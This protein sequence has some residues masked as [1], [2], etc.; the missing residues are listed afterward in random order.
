MKKAAKANSANQAEWNENVD[1][2][3]AIWD[4]IGG[5]LKASDPRIEAPSWVDA[6]EEDGYQDTQTVGRFWPEWL[7]KR[8]K[9]TYA[10]DDLKEYCDEKGI[11]RDKEF[12][13]PDGVVQVSR[14]RGLDRKQIENN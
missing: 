1:N 9:V 4:S 13:A 5:L 3:S 11:W 10:Q 7:L 2:H 14:V 12:G 8:E 6:E